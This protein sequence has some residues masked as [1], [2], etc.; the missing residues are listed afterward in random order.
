[1]LRLRSTLLLLFVGLLVTAPTVQAQSVDAVVNKMQAN[2]EKQ[3]DRIDTY[4]V[5]TNLYTSYNKKVMTDGE[6][7]FETETKMK[8]AETAFASTTSHSTAYGLHFDRLKKHATYGGTKT[9]DGANCHVLEVK[10]PKAL[11]AQMGDQAK[12]LT[13]YID[14]S[15]YV[16]VRMV[17]QTRGQGQA[18]AGSANEPTVTINMRDYKTVD[19]LTLPFRMEIQYDMNMSE[20]QKQ[21]MQKMMEKMENMPAQQ[22]EQMKKMMGESQMEMMKQMMSG[23]PVVVEVQDVKVNAP[24]PDGVF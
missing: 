2:Y 19:G 14:A 17:M 24:L 10:D 1:M 12:R 18:Q 22:R 21:Q 8:G 5:E 15:E 23:D 6:A 3:L 13:Y 20:Q 7:T 16:P 11:D 4:I 9:I